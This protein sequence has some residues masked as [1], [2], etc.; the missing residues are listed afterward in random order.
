MSEAEGSTPVNAA[1][2]RSH[3]DLIHGFSLDTSAY[4]VGRLNDPKEL[5][6]TSPC[7]KTDQ[8]SLANW[9]E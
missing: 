3:V 8:T 1:H 6:S 4:F 5:S 7:P 9:V 2:L